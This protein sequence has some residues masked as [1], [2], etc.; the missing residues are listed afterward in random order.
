MTSSAIG[1]AIIF[2]LVQLT[3]VGTESTSIYIASTTAKTQDKLN[4]FARSIRAYI[5]IGILWTAATCLVLSTQFGVKGVLMGLITNLLVM[6]YV[7]ARY[8]G[9]LKEIATEY[10][11]KVP[12]II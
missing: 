12:R 4:K 8:Q 6:I 2:A 10:G 1:Q 7:Y 5:F 3:L 11:L 9:V